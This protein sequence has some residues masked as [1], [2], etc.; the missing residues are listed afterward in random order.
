MRSSDSVTWAHSAWRGLGRALWMQFMAPVP[1]NPLITTCSLSLHALLSRPTP[2][3][4]RAPWR[5]PFGCTAGSPEH[6]GRRC[7]LLTLSTGRLRDEASTPSPLARSAHQ[8]PREGARVQPGAEMRGC[9][10]GPL[11]A[12]SLAWAVPPPP[13][14]H[15]CLGSFSSI[16][17]PVPANHTMPH[18]P[19]PLTPR[20]AS[21]PVR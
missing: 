14:T 15:I 13:T 1:S 17:Q 7:G 20:P 19:A 8:C 4:S 6:R 2:A 18:H 5:H 21:V 9:G 16:A 10:S 12:G 3:L 11:T